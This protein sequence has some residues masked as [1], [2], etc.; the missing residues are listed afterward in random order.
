MRRRVWPRTSKRS[1][2][3]RRP[4]KSLV[5]RSP[6]STHQTSLALFPGA[7]SKRPRSAAA[8]PSRYASTWLRAGI[9]RAP[10]YRLRRT[11]VG[12]T[13]PPRTPR[14]L[15]R[16]RTKTVFPLPSVPRRITTSPGRSRLP[17][18]AP[19]PRV[20]A[21]E[22]VDNDRHRRVCLAGTDR[23]RRFFL[24]AF[25]MVR[26]IRYTKFFMKP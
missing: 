11:K 23:V 5:N 14:A 22:F 18:F 7:S 16:P 20:A 13:M 17:N 2:Q 1:T 24:G 21:G 15:P 10:P 12:L 25:D 8:L 9:P 19:A 3:R 26:S 6:H 4:R